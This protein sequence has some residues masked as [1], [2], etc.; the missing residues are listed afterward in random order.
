MSLFSSIKN[1]MV[2]W[3][4]YEKPATEIPLSD[5]DRIS[6][7]LRPCDIILVEGRSRISEV[8]KVITQSPWSHSALYIGRLHD[9]EDPLAR[10]IVR[11]HFEGRLDKQLLIESLLG[12]GTIISP[13]DKYKDFH[14]RICRPTGLTRKDAQKVIE[15]SIGH[16]GM[17]Y[18]LRQNIDLG[19]FL[20]PWRI[21]PRKWHST[22]FARAAGTP[23]KEIC[24]TMLAE[25]FDTVNFP[26]MPIVKA[27][28]QKGMLLY[29]RNPRL[30]TPRDFDHSPFFEIIKYPIV[31]LTD[32]AIYHQIKWAEQPPSMKGKKDSNDND[33]LNN[34]N[35]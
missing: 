18:D 14:I 11:N 35:K 13:L 5:F 30:F 7:E 17:K 8:I 26:I 10:N 12:E 3:L 32:T 22:L 29:H 28:K 4:K 1:K 27:D 9:I 20:L 33:Q 15:A 16:L 24:S 2:N 23:T 21:L 6:Y 19:R 31:E 34:K 25:A